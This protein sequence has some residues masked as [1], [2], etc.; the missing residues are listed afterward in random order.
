MKR[1]SVLDRLRLLEPRID[2]IEDKLR[3]KLGDDLR[4]LNEKTKIYGLVNSMDS[5]L[6]A[7][8]RQFK[9][10]IFLPKQTMINEIARSTIDNA[11]NELR[12]V[13]EKEVAARLAKEKAEY[14]ASPWSEGLVPEKQRKKAIRKLRKMAKK[15]DA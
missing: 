8:E 9:P 6:L 3:D 13:I 4:D 14:E 5:R 1:P 7:I 11:K 12:P 2:R 15:K 10:I